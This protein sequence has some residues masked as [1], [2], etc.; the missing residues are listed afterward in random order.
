M[1]VPAK[2]MRREALI[3]FDMCALCPCG[4]A[5]RRPFS[6][7]SALADERGQSR[8]QHID[9]ELEIDGQDGCF[10]AGIFLHG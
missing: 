8:L 1:A 10:R 6:P 9:P 4:T 2:A 7:H 5:S 3:I